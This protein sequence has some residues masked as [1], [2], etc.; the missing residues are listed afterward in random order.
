MAK[1]YHGVGYTSLEG[2]MTMSA[3]TYRILWVPQQIFFCKF[4]KSVGHEEKYYRAYKLLKE[5]TFDTY[6]MKNEGMA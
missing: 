4:C 1:D 5:N 6:L 2:I 3:Y